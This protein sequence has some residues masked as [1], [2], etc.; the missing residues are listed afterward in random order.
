MTFSDKVK[1]AREVVGMTQ[2][3][4]AAKTGVSQRTIA[5]YESGGAIARRSTTEKLARA[6]KVSV[7]YLTEE[8]CTDPLD[9]IEKDGYVEQARELYGASGVRDMDAL[10]RDN[11]ALFA[12]G[13]LSQDQKD[14]F[15]EAVMKAYLTC[16]EEAKEKYGRKKG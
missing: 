7:K 11:A 4:L 16:K 2:N 12:G 3:E 14:A 9:E 13:E 5:S 10:L 8:N 6:L 15:F 1:R